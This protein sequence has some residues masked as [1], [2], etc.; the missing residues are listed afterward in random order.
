MG[1][2]YESTNNAIDALVKTFETSDYSPRTA[3]FY[4]DQCRRVVT[5]L[6]D[7]S[8][9]DVTP[10]D[11]KAAV[12]AMRADGL[13]VS[14]IKDYSHA[15]LRLLSFIG[16]HTAANTKIIHQADIRPTVDWLTPEN[17]RLVMDTPKT[18][19]QQLIVVLALGMGLRRIE[20]IR[21]KMSDVHTDRGYISVTGKGRGG[22][23]LR[24]VPFHPRFNEALGDWLR[25]RHTMINPTKYTPDNLL[26]WARGGRCYPY[27]DRKATGIDGQLNRVSNAVGIG[28]SFHTLRRTFGRL[29]WLS[30][31]SV[32]TIAK[33]LGHTS[34]EQTLSYIGANLDDM[35]GAMSVFSL[36]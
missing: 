25:V 26:I 7:I 22:G 16:N 30:G 8:L 17:A 36:Q 9:Y 27:S 1:R 23:K 33:M 29:M 11:V 21:L 35:A 10:E 28:F 6:G 14:T 15:L 2:R 12:S 34:T 19:A 18:P 13:A 20:I 31:V 24:A 4:R 5:Y 32:V 3:R